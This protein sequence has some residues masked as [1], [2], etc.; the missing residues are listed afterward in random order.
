M[1]WWTNHG[2]RERSGQSLG[3]KHWHWVSLTA[4]TSTCN[5]VSLKRK[6]VPTPNAPSLAFSSYSPISLRPSSL[7]LNTP[8]GSATEGRNEGDEGDEDEDEEACRW[9]RLQSRTA[10]GQPPGTNRQGPTRSTTAQAA[11]VWWESR[12]SKRHNK[13]G[14]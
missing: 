3:D 6:S 7:I 1:R 2:A 12:R 13:E 9:Y 11:L 14:R 10:R 5:W 4:G 8:S